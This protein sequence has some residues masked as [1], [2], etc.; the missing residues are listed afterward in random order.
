MEIQHRRDNLKITW[1]YG[2]EMYLLISE[3]VLK[4]QG[5]MG[6]FPRKK[7][8]GG[9]PFPSPNPSMNTQPPVGTNKDSVRCWHY[10]FNL[11]TGHAALVFHCGDGLSN[12]ALAP[13]LLPQQTHENFANTASPF[14]FPAPYASM[15]LPPPILSWMQ[16]SAT[17]LEVCKHPQEGP[18]RLQ[19]DLCPGKRER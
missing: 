6:D 15:D 16:S 1:G 11:L 4:G 10:L 7:G 17:S 12:W 8:A 14:P 19:S 5:S 3:H 9:C 18:V 2:R 13:G